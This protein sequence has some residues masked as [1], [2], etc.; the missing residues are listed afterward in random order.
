MTL[1]V[2]G[3]AVEE[4]VVAGGVVVAAVTT[5][6]RGGGVSTHCTYSVYRDV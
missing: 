4:G 3:V 6:N 1:G 5:E 2:V